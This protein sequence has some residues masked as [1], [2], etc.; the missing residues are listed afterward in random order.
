MAQQTFANGELNSS[1]RSKLNGNA[2]DADLRLVQNASEI[3]VNTAAIGD[4]ETQVAINTPQIQTNTAVLL[5]LQQLNPMQVIRSTDTVLVADT[6]EHGE[7]TICY[8][9]LNTA[10]R[11][12]S[13]PA[14]APTGSRIQVQ[15]GSD[16]TTSV[17]ITVD[18]G[19]LIDFGTTAVLSLNSEHI[20]FV[21]DGVQ[22][23]SR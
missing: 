1:V 15:N 16:A 23:W 5:S 12:V 11:T 22:W 21:S 7:D 13:L 8:V 17:T 18:G 2:T 4:V 3:G 19:G 20:E 6:P 14:A 9:M 10:N